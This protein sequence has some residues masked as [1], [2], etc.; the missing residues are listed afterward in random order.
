MKEVTMPVISNGFSS[1]EWRVSWQSASA[2]VKACNVSLA[3]AEMKA[4]S[5]LAALWRRWRMW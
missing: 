1:I 2:G 3:L 5:Q 4:Q